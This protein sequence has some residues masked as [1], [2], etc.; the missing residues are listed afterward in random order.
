MQQWPPLMWARLSSTTLSPWNYLQTQEQWPP[1]VW[2]I[3]IPPM[4]LQILFILART[5]FPFFGQHTFY[6]S[7]WFPFI[8]SHIP[9]APLCRDGHPSSLC[10]REACGLWIERCSWLA[11]KLWELRQWFVFGVASMVELGPN[12]RGPLNALECLL[13]S[14]LIQV[15]QQNRLFIDSISSN[16]YV[17]YFRQGTTNA[18]KAIIPTFLSQSVCIYISF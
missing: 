18:A 9:L 14:F 1:L 17:K 15:S 12:E 10:G 7:N 13:P 11:S 5:N 6:S 3:I 16:V 2:A 4:V 8:P